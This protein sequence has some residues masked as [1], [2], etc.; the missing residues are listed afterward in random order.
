[1]K[2][3]KY[4]PTLPQVTA[5]TVCILIATVAAAFLISRFPPLQKFINDNSVTLKL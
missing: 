3:A 5:E 4:L 1:M 2:S